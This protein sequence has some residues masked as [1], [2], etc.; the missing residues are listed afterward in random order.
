MNVSINWQIKTFAELNTNE[1]YDILKLRID[2]FVVEQSCYYPDL[3]NLDRH[4]ETIHLF[5]Y[6]DNELVSYLR[7]L[8]KGLSDETYPSIGRVII[9]P[10][11]RGQ[12]LGHQLMTQ[13]LTTA[14][15]YFPLQSIKIS[16]QEHLA[17]FYQQHGFNQI[18]KMYFEDGIAH[19][20]MLKE[21]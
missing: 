5:N 21:K 20:A 6:Q 2:V 10:I 8:P 16:A 11:A 13:A 15:Q 1:L 19:I 17:K 4:P 14:E 7:L 18:S 12:G 3:D 9:A